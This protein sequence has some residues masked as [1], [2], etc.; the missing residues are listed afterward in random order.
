MKAKFCWTCGS[1]KDPRNFPPDSEQYDGR[2]AECARCAECREMARGMDG[3]TGPRTTPIEG[4][5]RRAAPRNI[6]ASSRAHALASGLRRRSTS[7][8]VTTEA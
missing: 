7:G 2:A 3:E 8:L 4:E 6:T 5:G 1:E